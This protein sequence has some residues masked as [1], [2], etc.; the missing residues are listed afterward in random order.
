MVAEHEENLKVHTHPTSTWLPTAETQTQPDS[1]NMMLFP[2]LLTFTRE[3]N[4]L[5]KLRYRSKGWAT[6]KPT[7]DHCPG[8]ELGG[9]GVTARGGYVSAHMCESGG[10]VFSAYCIV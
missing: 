2:G 5:T 6:D 10:N 1:D 8:V 3:R 7:K 4:P 9:V